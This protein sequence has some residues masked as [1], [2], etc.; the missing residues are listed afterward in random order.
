[1][2][3]AKALAQKLVS[4]F[5]L[6]ASERVVFSGGVP[7]S[8]MQS[9]VLELLVHHKTFPPHWSL[10]KPFDGAILTLR[11]D[12][13]CQVT[14]KGEIGVGRYETIET[15]EYLDAGVAVGEYVRRFFGRE[16]DGIPINW[17]A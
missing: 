4:T 1:M 8:L 5:H 7:G 9:A 3:S 11:A 12:G 14:W 6:D 10:E 15:L 16:V 17:S 13:S 2:T